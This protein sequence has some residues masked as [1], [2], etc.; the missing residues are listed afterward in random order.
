MRLVCTPPCGGGT[1]PSC[2]TV[3][4]AAAR[5]RQ[6]C[7]RDWF[8]LPRWNGAR[9]SRPV[10]AAFTHYRVNATPALAACPPGPIA[11]TV[12]TY[13]PGGRALKKVERSMVIS[14]FASTGGLPRSDDATEPTSGAACGYTVSR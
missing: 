3:I 13:A 6:P 12:A 14:R 9:L 5:C 2:T 8:R 1:G 11:V 10:A 4:R 7:Q